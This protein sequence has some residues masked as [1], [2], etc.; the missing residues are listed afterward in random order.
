[1]TTAKLVMLSSYNATILDAEPF[2]Q[3]EV[4]RMSPAGCAAFGDISKTW[5]V[6]VASCHGCHD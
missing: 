2:A 4:V 1:M 6:G 3:D 5:I